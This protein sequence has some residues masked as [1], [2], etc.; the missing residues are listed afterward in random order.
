M[1]VTASAT[2]VEGLPSSVAKDLACQVAVVFNKNAENGNCSQSGYCGVR[3][4]PNDVMDGNKDYDFFQENIPVNVATGS[5][6]SDFNDTDIYKR[7]ILADIEDLGNNLVEIIGTQPVLEGEDVKASPKDDGT[8]KAECN[9]L[10]YN[11]V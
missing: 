8:K 11:G 1:T 2:E 3:F 6:L 4:S 9:I 5:D 7:N 10:L